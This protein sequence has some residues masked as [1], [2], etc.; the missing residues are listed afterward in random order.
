M[1][2][3]RV[4]ERKGSRNV[5]RQIL[6]GLFSHFCFYFTE[7][8]KYLEWTSIIFLMY[9]IC[10]KFA[11]KAF[12]PKV[13]IPLCQGHVFCIEAHSPDVSICFPSLSDLGPHKFYVCLGLLSPHT[14]ATS[15]TKANSLPSW[16]GSFPSS[17]PT[18]HGES[19]YF[20]IQ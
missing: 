14:N 20:N 6:C 4:G 3:S 1:K 8:S 12:C 19:G 17:P 16:L 5:D 18:E 2:R 10:S 15:D 7:Y 9:N 11:R 13:Y